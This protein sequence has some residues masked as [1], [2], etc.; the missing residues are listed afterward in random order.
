MHRLAGQVETVDY[1]YLWNYPSRGE[2]SAGRFYVSFC[3]NQEYKP[4]QKNP[5]NVLYNCNAHC[6][7][8][9]LRLCP[10]GEKERFLNDMFYSRFLRN[11]PQ[12]PEAGSRAAP[13]LKNERHVS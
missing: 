6:D 3:K 11:R 1:R 10:D 8:D 5:H 13:N 2:R 9:S 7:S 4:A 12:S